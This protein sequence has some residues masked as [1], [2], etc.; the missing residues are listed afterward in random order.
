MYRPAV[1][2]QYPVRH[3]SWWYLLATGYWLLISPGRTNRARRH[4]RRSRCRRR[5]GRLHHHAGLRYAD[6][7]LR[8]RRR[9]RLRVS[10]HHRPWWHRPWWIHR[11][12][13]CDVL[14]LARLTR[15]AALALL[16]ERKDRRV[17]RIFIRLFPLV[18]IG[19][20]GRWRG[21]TKRCVPFKAEFGCCAG[22]ALVATGGGTLTSSPSP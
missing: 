8:L 2:T 17:R 11:A 22:R 14:E 20:S 12:I 9:G 18:E 6:R 1:S 4:C 16:R 21:G 7:R 19:L 10:R 3:W 5:R 15:E 13:R